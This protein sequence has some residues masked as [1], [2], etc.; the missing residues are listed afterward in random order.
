MGSYDRGLRLV[1]AALIAYLFF[2]GKIDGS[3]GTVLIVLA[4]VFALTSFVGVCPLYLPFGFSTLKKKVPMNKNAT[5]VD[6]RTRAE[7]Q[8]GHVANSINIPLQEL[9]DRLKELRKLPQPLVLC[10]ASGARSAMLI[11]QVMKLAVASKV[12]LVSATAPRRS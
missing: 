5:I 12:L 4:A 3:T 11:V 1:A 7:Y 2:T 6:V 9:P 8:G 10:C